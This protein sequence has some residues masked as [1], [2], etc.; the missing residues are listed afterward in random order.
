MPANRGHGE[1]VKGPEDPGVRSHTPVLGTSCL[2]M[3]MALVD[4]VVQEDQASCGSPLTPRYLSPPAGL[5]LLTVEGSS[6]CGGAD[7]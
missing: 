7:S 6:G 4:E 1:V 2:S 5:C 3:A